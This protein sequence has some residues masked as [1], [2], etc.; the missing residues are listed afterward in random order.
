M[1]DFGAL[2]ELL[3][4][5]LKKV[6]VPKNYASLRKRLMENK[7][8]RELPLIHESPEH[9]VRTFFKQRGNCRLE[10]PVCI[11]VLT[12]C[13]SILDVQNRYARVLKIHDRISIPHVLVLCFYCP[14][15]ARVRSRARIIA[16]FYWAL[17]EI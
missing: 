16:I 9:Y 6:E 1:R 7:P 13:E 8:A 11:Q 15:D 4:T 14:G 3:L 17:F 10:I 2:T 5:R 12:D